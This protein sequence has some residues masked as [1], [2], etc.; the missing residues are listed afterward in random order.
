MRLI[1]LALAGGRVGSA[2]DGG[3]LGGGER[4]SLTRIVAAM[5]ARID[6]GPRA[7]PAR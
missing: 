4:R 3:A 1:K 2:V 6:A 7:R 5:Q